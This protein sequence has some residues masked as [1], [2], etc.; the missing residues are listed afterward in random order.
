M[1]KVSRKKLTEVENRILADEIFVRVELDG[2][3]GESSY[4]C[5]YESKEDAVDSGDHDGTVVAT[6]KL[7]NV[8]R[9]ALKR[10]VELVSVDD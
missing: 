3:D 9:L 6:Y 4:S 10:S 2:D 7:M 5:N 1:A 8:E